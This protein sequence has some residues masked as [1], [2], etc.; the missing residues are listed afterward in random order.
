V[1]HGLLRLLPPLRDTRL[2]DLQMAE[3]GQDENEPICDVRLGLAVLD[4]AL[5]GG[6]L[7]R[8]LRRWGAACEQFLYE[9]TST[10]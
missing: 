10:A 9:L 4:D 5:D 3:G 6:S 7:L 8:G 1:L 2:G